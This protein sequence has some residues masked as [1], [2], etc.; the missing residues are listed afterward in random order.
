MS[1]SV[2]VASPPCKSTKTHCVMIASPIL[3]KRWKSKDPTPRK[4]VQ[5]QR[6]VEKM[7]LAQI[8]AILQELG[9]A[10]DIADGDCTFEVCVERLVESEWAPSRAA[11]AR[12][13]EERAKPVRTLAQKEEDR[14]R[15]CQL[16]DVDTLSASEM[17]LWLAR[18]AGRVPNESPAAVANTSTRRQRMLRRIRNQM[19]ERTPQWRP[20]KNHRFADKDAGRAPLRKKPE[21]VAPAS[22]F[23]GITEVAPASQHPLSSFGTFLTTPLEDTESFPLGHFWA[24]DEPHALSSPSLDFTGPAGIPLPEFFDDET[25]VAEY[26]DQTAAREDGVLFDVISSEMWAG[27]RVLLLSSKAL[28]DGVHEWTLTVEHSSTALQEMGIVAN[29]KLEADQIDKA[30]LRQTPGVGACAVFGSASEGGSVH[31][32]S[33]DADG[34]QR[35]GGNLPARYQWSRG[36]KIKLKVDLDRGNIECFHNGDTVSSAMSLQRSTYH[37]FVSFTGSCRYELS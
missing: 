25:M 24:E 20:Q 12:Y 15:L 26:L 4:L 29:A 27:D 13:E 2:S 1:S 8:R 19:Q 32:G 36:D 6:F 30:G 21:S 18:N 11:I 16:E 5:K 28:S 3:W 22:Q 14:V 35:C 31:C 17:K 33:F 7:S 34:K 9:L 37:A 10:A 23:L